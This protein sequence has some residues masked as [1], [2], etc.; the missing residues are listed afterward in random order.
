[1]TTALFIGRFQPFHLGHYDT[2][3]TILNECD[4]IIIGIGSSQY[5]YQRN[6]PFTYDERFDMIYDTLMNNM[7]VN[8]HRFDVLPIPDIHDYDNWVKHVC[9]IVPEFDVAYTGNPITWDLFK[10]A[11]IAVKRVRI[12]KN[13]SGTIVRQAICD[14]AD[15]WDKMLPEWSE[16]HVWK[17]NGH[18]RL[19]HLLGHKRKLAIDVHGVLN[20][21][22]DLL[23]VLLMKLRH[24]GY[25][26]HIL[27]GPPMPFMLD[28]LDKMGIVDDTHYDYLFSI[29]DYLQS[30]GANMWQDGRERWYASDE[31]WDSAKGIYC[32]EHGIR[33][34][35]DDTFAYEKYM[36]GFT[37]FHLIE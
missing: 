12:C 35:I 26:I 20:T 21:K 5:A 31:D 2:V 11:G 3:E 4:H 10:D 34:I 7:N 28:E 23:K 8:Y 32:K 14:D 13:I 36:P 19:K 18:T 1:M 33:D 22:P 17:C 27:S 30:I 6:N 15:G 24:A 25:E 16:H 37:K 9:K 29:V